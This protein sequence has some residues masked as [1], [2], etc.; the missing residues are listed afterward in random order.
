MN[1]NNPATEENI[2]AEEIKLGIN[3][4]AQYRDFMLRSNGAEGNIGEKSYLVIQPIEEIKQL[5]EE[6]AV[7]E[8]TP[9]LI[10]FGSD[11]GETA[12]AFDK[13]SD[14]ILIVEFPFESI[15]ISDVKLCAYTFDEFLQGLYYANWNEFSEC[16]IN[17]GPIH[18][19]LPEFRVL[20]FCPNK[21]RNAW[22]YATCGMS[23]NDKMQGVELFI[24]APTENDFL[25]E[26]LAKCN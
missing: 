24:L 14:D 22:T 1:F 20:K 21:K 13:R 15:D 7:N 6:Y 4:P 2:K 5:N 19:L 3:F 11:G 18:E 10:Y 16:V 17:K 26:L 9:G 12:Y 25:I 23:G 8:F